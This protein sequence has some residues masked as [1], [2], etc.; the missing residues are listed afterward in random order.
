MA[1]MREA[2]IAYNENVTDYGLVRAVEAALREEMRVHA[3]GQER[4]LEL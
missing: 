1:A 4:G 3:G 2:G